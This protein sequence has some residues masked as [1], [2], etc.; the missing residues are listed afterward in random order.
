[1]KV[2]YIGNY[3]DGTGWSHAAIEYISALIT[4]GV[5][6]VPR[7][8]RDNDS[9]IEPPQDI[10]ER[11]QQSSRDCD[12]VIQHVRPDNME[13]NGHFNKN[14]GIYFTETSHFRRSNWAAHINL[15]D[16][17]WLANEQM[18]EAAKNSGVTIPL[19]LAPIPCD[20]SKYAQRYE[21]YPIP[22]IKDTFVFYTIGELNR[23]KNL[24]ALLKAFHLEFNLQEPVSLLIKASLPGHSPMEANRHLSKIIEDVKA[25]L[26]LYPFSNLY[27]D[28][29][30]I[31]QHLTEQEM[32]R[33]HASCDCFVSPSF[34]EAW[35]IP[36]FDAMAM[37]KT[38]ICT[39]VGGM[40]DFLLVKPRM[41]W[42]DEPFIDY[43]SHHVEPAQVAGWLIPSY[44]TPVFGMTEGFPPH[45]FIGDETWQDI[46]I[47]HLRQAMREAYSDTKTRKEKAILGIERAYDYGRDILGVKMKKLLEQ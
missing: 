16:E 15:L 10:L 23:R 44:P 26:K 47:P 43:A 19:K 36:A 25:N 42:D 9:N 45:L 31:T 5:D 22:A 24:V 20:T 35:S 11:E 13:Y 27:H 32:M 40:H 21:P 37:G 3:R 29:I 7:A 33:L 41:E 14:I 12:V 46:S 4:A 8:V 34:G 1:M 39:D 28:E 2:L 38:P 18:F 6:V 17:A 30:L